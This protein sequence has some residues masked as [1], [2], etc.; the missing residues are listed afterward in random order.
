MGDVITGGQES[1][2]EDLQRALGQARGAEQQYYG[3][4]VGFLQ[5]YQ[6]AGSQALSAALSQLGVTPTQQNINAPTST[7]TS[8]TLPQSGGSLME[9]L[10]PFFQQMTTSPSQTTIPQT[11]QTAQATAQDPA[12]FIRQAESGF[13]QTPAQRF[14]QQQATQGVQN[15]LESQGIAG[16][17][18]GAQQL[19]QTIANITGGQQQQYLQNLLGVRQQTLGDLLSAGQ[20]GLGAAGTAARGAF[21][22]GQ[23]LAQLLGQ[24]GQAQYGEDVARGSGINQLMGQVGAIGGL[25]GLL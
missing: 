16:S 12:A 20:L 19:A 17:G 25:A 8:P 3:R 7:T 9:D 6:T 1:G 4:G 14:E 2:Y 18:A 10:R 21:G 15:L 23:T 22:T 13:Q 11:A 5:P 24:T